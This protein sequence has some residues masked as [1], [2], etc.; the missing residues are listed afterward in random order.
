M[1]N[2]KRSNTQE[3]RNKRLIIVFKYV[4]LSLQN[5]F[6]YIISCYQTKLMLTRNLMQTCIS[7]SVTLQ[8]SLLE[9]KRIPT[10]FSS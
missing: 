2:F 3:S 7:G 4:L 10:V 8:N 6:M 9:I 1:D 5:P